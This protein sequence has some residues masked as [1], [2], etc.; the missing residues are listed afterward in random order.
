MLEKE[1]RLNIQQIADYFETVV[2]VF[3]EQP[4]KVVVTFEEFP[5]QVI[6]HLSV[7]DKDLLTLKKFKETYRSLNHI[8]RKATFANIGRAGTLDDHFGVTQEI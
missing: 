4:E 3:T 2:K 5:R 1:D 8:L 6:F 7:G